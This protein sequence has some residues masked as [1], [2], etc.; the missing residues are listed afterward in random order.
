[1]NIISMDNLIETSKTTDSI[2]KGT[3]KMKHESIS[4]VI[5]NENLRNA[6]SSAWKENLTNGTEHSFTKF[7]Q[8]ISD[9]AKDTIG[10]VSRARSTGGGSKQWKAD[11]RDQFSG[12]GK[13][14]LMFN[15]DSS[16]GQKITECLDQYDTNGEDTS[17]YREHTSAQNKFWI[18]FS[19]PAGSEDN[20]EVIFEI[21]IHNS[22][23]YD[24]QHTV[25]LSLDSVNNEGETMNG[26]PSKLG[27]EGGEVKVKAAK[28][29]AKPKVKKQ[30]KEPIQTSSLDDLANDINLAIEQSD[31]FPR[32]EEDIPMIDTDSFQS[33]DEWDRFLE[34]Q[35]LADIDD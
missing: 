6:L 19:K 16:V 8:T 13:G 32:E 12:R 28:S 35:G 30:K 20:Q 4:T 5:D 15:I 1:M 27:F 24:R 26:T 2:W 34:E 7:M 33:L 31:I 22:K 14:W 9:I 21:R 11:I 25:Q 29:P 17:T 18:R 23:D 10:P 3:V